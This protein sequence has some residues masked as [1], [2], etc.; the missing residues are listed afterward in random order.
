MIE[1]CLFLIKENFSKKHVIKKFRS[2]NILI[3]INDYK[4]SKVLFILNDHYWK[5]KFYFDCS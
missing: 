5:G 2:L 4:W 1:T 3:T